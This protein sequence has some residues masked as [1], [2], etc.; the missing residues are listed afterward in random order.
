MSDR[1]LSTLGFISALSTALVAFLG[2]SAGAALTLWVTLKT[3][4]FT[5]P[6][7]HSNYFAAFLV[8]LGFTVI[9]FAVS[10][11]VLAAAF[12]DVRKIRRESEQE[13]RQR[14]L[15]AGREVN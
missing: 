9:L 14:D 1:E 13:K 7:S 8:S 10:V 6:T 5:D 11:I 4:A 2:I 15:L 12:L 3:I